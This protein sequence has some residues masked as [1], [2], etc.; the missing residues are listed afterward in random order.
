MLYFDAREM[1]FEL[2]RPIGFNGI[3]LAANRTDLLDR[4]LNIELEGISE[5]KIKLF[6]KEI[7]PEFERLKPFVL[8]YIFDTVSKVL[9][10]EYETGGKGLGLK[11]R[12]RMADWEE[13]AEIIVRC[14][15]FKPFQLL[16][17]YRTNREKK[18]E[19]ILEESPVAQAKTSKSY[20][21]M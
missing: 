2:I 21:L 17:A 13:F 18:T 12:S 8:S 7:I 4:G 11:S 1:V 19:V 15:G 14:I 9:A 16:D 10:F 20:I 3:S 5:I 6:D